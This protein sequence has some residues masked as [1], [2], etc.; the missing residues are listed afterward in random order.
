MDRKYFD[1]LARVLFQQGIR[2]ELKQDDNL[3]VL[4]DGQPACHV[5]ATS[6]MF[7]AP[8]NLRTREADELYHRTAPVAEMVREYMTAI[9]KAPLLNARALDEPLPSSPAWIGF[10]SFPS[11]FRLSSCI[12]RSPSAPTSEMSGEIWRTTRSSLSNAQF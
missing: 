3:T 8:G 7:V 1:E 5:G 2:A 6:Q 9:E 10:P 4:L 12:C 11:P